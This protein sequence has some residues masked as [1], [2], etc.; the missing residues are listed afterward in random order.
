[1]LACRHGRDLCHSPLDA[2][3]P[4]AMVMQ[5][6]LLGCARMS[7]RDVFL[8][9]DLVMNICMWIS[10]HSHWDGRLPP[11]AIIKPEPLW[12]GKQILSMILPRVSDGGWGKGL[13]PTSLADHPM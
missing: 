2:M 12:T 7:R 1:M 11:P 13:E 10:L 3:C 5:D 8:R 9:R 4:V 6:S